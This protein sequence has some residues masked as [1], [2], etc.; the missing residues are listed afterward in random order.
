VS[1]RYCN[2]KA[3]TLQELLQ[4][5]DRNINNSNLSILDMLD[6]EDCT[7][8]DWHYCGMLKGIL[9]DLKEDLI[10]IMDKNATL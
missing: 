7:D 1:E 5:I 4:A 2:I 3:T 9:S 10:G 8:L 6:N